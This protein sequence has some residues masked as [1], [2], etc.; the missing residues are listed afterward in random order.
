VAISNQIECLA[1]KFIWYTQE[2]QYIINKGRAMKQ[3]LFLLFTTFPVFAMESQTHTLLDRLPADVSLIILKYDLGDNTQEALK[4]FERLC[5]L[6]PQSRQN[7]SMVK[8]FLSAVED[9]LSLSFSSFNQL[10]SELQ[11]SLKLAPCE[12]EALETW[13][14]ENNCLLHLEE[15]MKICYASLA[16]SRM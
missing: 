8:T 7:F 13:M 15:A 12:N 5:V 2:Q 9:T 10:A 3:I 11:G 1:F 14:N 6:R 16:L 4:N